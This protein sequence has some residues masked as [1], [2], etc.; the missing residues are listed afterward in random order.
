M[1][2]I[3]QIGLLLA[4][5]C[6]TTVAA[7]AQDRSGR[8][9]P[10]GEHPR[11][12]FTAADL[13]AIR[14]RAASPELAFIMQDLRN[15]RANMVKLLE[16]PARL[17]QERVKLA[18]DSWDGF[19]R[20]HKLALLA[21]AT[22]DEADVKPAVTYYKLWLSTRPEEPGKHPRA[23]W[24]GECEWAL[25]YDWL[26]AWL[27]APARQHSER[28]FASYMLE[29]MEQ[30][31]GRDWFLGG[32]NK[33]NRAI[34]GANWLMIAAPSIFL[35]DMVLEGR[36]GFNQMI[37]DHC[38][39]LFRENLT[40]WID[41]D[42]A[43]YEGMSYATGYGT[44]Y[45]AQG[46]LA[47]K[48]RGLDLGQESNVRKMP[49]WFAYETLPWGY[50]AF[51]FNKSGGTYNGTWPFINCAAKVTG[52]LG[53]WMLD[54]ASFRQHDG[55]RLNPLISL[56]AGIADSNTATRSSM[57]LSKWF[58]PRG[59][60]FNRS[61]WG[62]RDAQFALFTNPMGA[63]HT[64]ADNGSFC[65]AANGAYF[66]ADSGAAAY[67]S[68][69][70][71]IVMIDGVGQ[72]Q[73]E[74]SVD[75]FF[76][77]AEMDAYADMASIDAKLSFDRILEG[78]GDGYFW[79]E[80]YPVD[81][82]DRWTLFVRGATG[83]LALV[84]DDIAKDDQEREYDFLL[85]TV[86]NNHTR[87]NGR[88]IQVEERYGG[89]YLFTPSPDK[90]AAFVADDV[91]V[92][93]YHGWL[94]VR[95]VPSP[96]GWVNNGIVVNGVNCSYETTR[97]GRGFFREGWQWLRLVPGK[98]DVIAHKG[99]PFRV[100]VNSGSGG[101][102][103]LLLLTRNYALA[104]DAVPAAD[105]DT[106]LVRADAAEIP[107]SN[108]WE[109][110]SAPRGVM[111]AV[112]LGATPPVVRLEPP[113][114]PS[115]RNC[116]H[117]VSKGKTGK[118]ALAM[119]PHDAGDG[120]RMACPAEGMGQVAV[121]TSADGKDVIAAAVESPVM[122]AL[123]ETDAKLAVVS[124]AATT[125]AMPSRYAMVH[126]TGFKAGGHV[127]TRVEGAPASVSCDGSRIT[128]RGEGGSTIH[129]A[130]LGA[131]DVKV[132]G[133][134][135]P[136]PAGVDGLVAIAI[137]RLPHAWTVSLSDDGRVA[138]VTGNGLQPLSFDAPA[139]NRVFVNGIERFFAKDLKGFAYPC[140]SEGTTTFQ[141]RNRLIPRDLFTRCANR[142]EAA[143]GD[144]T[145]FLAQ[146]P[147]RP[148]L[149][150]S[151][152]TV[153]VRLPVPVKG[154]YRI[155]AECLA[156]EGSVR[157][158]CDGN[159]VVQKDVGGNGATDPVR[160]EFER[161]LSGAQVDLAFTGTGALGIAHVDFAPQLTPILPNAWM[162]IGPFY[163]NITWALDQTAMLLAK[164][165]G[166]ESV[167]DKNLL[168]RG[169]TGLDGALQWVPADS[170]EG[171]KKLGGKDAP[172]LWYFPALARDAGVNF[173]YPLGVPN[174][175]L[176]YAVTW[177]ESPDDRD[178][179]IGIGCDWIAKAWLNGKALTSDRSA[180][181]KALDTAE[182]S[183]D[184]IYMADVRLK[185]GPNRFMVK[186]IGGAGSSSLIAKI[187][188]PGD[189]KFKPR[190]E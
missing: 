7:V 93:N 69:H 168:S 83:P 11:L 102:I 182:F 57:P 53:R 71:N 27:D 15:F 178:A 84:A 107:A 90:K 35:M 152:G 96:Q 63:G 1:K 137:P 16:D 158:S 169:Y 129:C 6:L 176:C 65:L 78:E 28:V 70:H 111:D 143:L 12:L 31:M 141:F 128:V 170:R 92:G 146:G 149:V 55:N 172:I 37:Y 88:W 10:P 106:I 39:R 124:Y 89:P 47:L 127:L 38:V 113:A 154:A 138:Q 68:K 62:E 179:R 123:V 5:A 51:D 155:G 121:V 36:P 130:P 85:H 14:A 56:I 145:R 66:V 120:R 188:D 133:A 61:G 181:T 13:P 147:V 22:A 9:P 24:G 164:D 165:F 151:S 186:L 87:Y 59:Q 67:E 117:A 64:H 153:K 162:T 190:P 185:K 97:F 115:T 125:E 177:I 80:H 95:S 54:Q 103:A 76:R 109:L 42:G 112:F 142:G 3:M 139:L 167:A 156:G 25:A 166:P 174:R 118:F 23:P 46:M 173:R 161:T 98:K 32:P 135:L 2:R 58:Q 99:G 157:V 44:H 134:V 180:A 43:L 30:M 18:A 148:L 126:G 184:T 82:A 8:T 17:E 131:R 75:C 150:S 81:R 187:S 77:W 4:I 26:H 48:L 116:L 41:A 45:I 101:R 136:M 132:N 189:L 29:P 183:S 34:S 86:V 110:A 49:E 171:L 33:T 73:R 40:E 60:F 105:A 140:L 159:P 94:L 21:L 20:I 50:E 72:A 91:P 119:L 52:G 160:I 100:D 104:P 114:A 79:R 163:T 122:G 144:T 108:G 74:S 175:G 19:D